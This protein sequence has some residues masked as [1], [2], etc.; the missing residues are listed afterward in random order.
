MEQLT[1]TFMRLFMF[2]PWLNAFKY[3]QACS[4]YLA[5][6]YFNAPI[7]YIFMKLTKLTIHH[8]ARPHCSDHLQSHGSASPCQQTQ[9]SLS[10]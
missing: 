9:T 1:R 7:A 2:G 4:D 5:Y 10:I 3:M 8:S 6:P